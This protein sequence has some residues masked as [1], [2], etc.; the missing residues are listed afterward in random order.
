M[1]KNLPDGLI[2]F[3]KGIDDGK[4]FGTKCSNCGKIYFPPKLICRNCS[5]EAKEFVELPNS[6][7]LINFVNK[8]GFDGKNSKKKKDKTIC[9]LIQVDNSDTHFMQTIFFKKKKDLTKGMKLKPVFVKN[10]KDQTQYIAGF[11]PLNSES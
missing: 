3:Y 11:E 4:I 8:Y 5:G 6:A 10:P 7:T 9:G 2:E 1:V